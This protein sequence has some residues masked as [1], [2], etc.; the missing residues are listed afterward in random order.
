MWF[1][2]TAVLAEIEGGQRPAPEGQTRVAKVAGPQPVKAQ[3][4]QP[5]ATRRVA[6]LADV[7]VLY[8]LEAKDAGSLPVGHE[9]AKPDFMQDLCQHG[10]SVAGKPCTWTGRPV[11]PAE[12]RN[13]SEWQRHGPDGRF[14][15]ACCRAWVS[16][17]TALA[18]AEARNK[19]KLEP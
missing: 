17:G 8:A 12:W 10:A 9:A 18:H 14:W 11:S 1:D 2:V 16:R 3:V 15:C 6:S 7:A 13:L 4:A 5:D 19:G